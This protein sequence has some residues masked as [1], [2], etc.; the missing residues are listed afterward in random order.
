MLAQIKYQFQYFI[1][2]HLHLPSLLKS[3][4]YPTRPQSPLPARHNIAGSSRR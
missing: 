2:L 4:P 1:N 3:S